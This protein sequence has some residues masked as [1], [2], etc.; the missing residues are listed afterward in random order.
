MGGFRISVVSHVLKYLLKTIK[1]LAERVVVQVKII[2][3]CMIIFKP[4][5]LAFSPS[6]ALSLRFF[7]TII[8]SLR[9]QI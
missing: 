3:Y 8:I 4:S 5:P 7:F 9:N 6:F 2:F 1:G